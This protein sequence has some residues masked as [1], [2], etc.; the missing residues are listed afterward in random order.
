MPHR[1]EMAL[2]VVLTTV[3]LLAPS[4]LAEPLNVTAE[5]T[6]YGSKDNCP[7]G[8]AIAY[9]NTQHPLAGGVGTYDDP[10]TFAGAQK[11]P[12]LSPG[13]TIIYVP[14]LQKYFRFEDQ[15]EECESDWVRHQRWHFDLWMGG[16]TV[17]PGPNLIACEN[18]M[19]KP[20]TTVLVDAPAGL[21]VN[22]TPLFNNLTLQ[23]IEPA[24]PCTD[25][26]NTCG[27]ECQIPESATCPTLAAQ[28][29][30]PYARF[31]QLNAAIASKCSA[32]DVIKQGTSVCMGG[33]CGD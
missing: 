14:G 10:I 25:K 9:P 15:C 33:T 5:T 3:F 31:L 32:G 16:D 12:A 27:N 2:G 26:G 28:L 17:T 29:L 21:P 7:P 1:G 4:I 20:K 19:T 23:C 22:A 13:K 18:Q 24:T 11:N 6:F 8:G 30:L